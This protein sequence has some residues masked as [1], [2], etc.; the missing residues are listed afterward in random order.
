MGFPLY[1]FLIIYLILAGVSMIYALLSL[2][3]VFNFAHLD[4]ASY[5][6]TGIFVA[7]LILIGFISASFIFPI[8][9]GTTI[10]LFTTS[11]SQSTLGL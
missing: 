10:E 11:Q 1:I 5:F 8:E 7:G 3:H 4:T 9:W 2:W 6:T